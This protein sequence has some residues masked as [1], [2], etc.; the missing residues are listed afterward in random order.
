MA[1]RIQILFEGREKAAE[2]SVGNHKGIIIIYANINT[3][4]NYLS[5]KKAFAL[6][7]MTYNN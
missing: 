4:Y 2:W 1:Y 6:V 3:F 5:Q 7:E